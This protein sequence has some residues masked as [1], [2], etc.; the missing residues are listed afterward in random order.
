MG[1]EPFVLFQAK[2]PAIC[3]IFQVNVTP[4]FSFGEYLSIHFAVY[5]VFE[6]VIKVAGKDAEHHPLS[7]M[8]PFSF[9]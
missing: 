7:V 2:G 6:T 1:G 4:C 9:Q 3:L 5:P 8:C